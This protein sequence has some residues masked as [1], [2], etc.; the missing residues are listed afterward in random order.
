MR[1]SGAEF[2]PQTT[3]FEVPGSHRL[4]LWRNGGAQEIAYAKLILA[5][6]ARELFLPFPGWTLPHVM[7]VGGLQALAKGGLPVT[8]K[9]I[10]VAGS[11]PLLL[12]VAA[13]L[14]AHGATVPLIA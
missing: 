10:V 6:G 2:L 11:G 9:R 12:A 3:V 1:A 4:G 14:Q 13:Y 7:G 5:T 8:G